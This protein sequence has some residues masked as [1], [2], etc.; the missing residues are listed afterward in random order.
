[1]LVDAQRCRYP[2]TESE[3]RDVQSLDFGECSKLKD[4]ALESSHSRIWNKSSNTAEMFETF[5]NNQKL[6][7]HLNGGTPGHSSSQS[8]LCLASQA[9]QHFPV[10]FL[11]QLFRNMFDLHKLTFFHVKSIYFNIMWT[12][13]L[14][15]HIHDYILH[16]IPI[17]FTCQI[18]CR[19]QMRES[20]T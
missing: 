2:E 17:N 4:E 19:M 20:K 14:N 15:M 1:M 10:V 11:L 12:H 6:M 8:V 9:D 16:H 7:Q 3:V 18:F 13:I 5:W